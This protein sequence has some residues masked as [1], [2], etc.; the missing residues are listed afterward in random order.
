MAEMRCVHH[1]EIEAPNGNYSNGTCQHCGETRQFTNYVYYDAETAATHFRE[2]RD[3]KIGR[4]RQLEI[5]R[6]AKRSTTYDTR[7]VW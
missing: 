4:Q 7:Y 5:E 2:T 3:Q 1:W 6:V